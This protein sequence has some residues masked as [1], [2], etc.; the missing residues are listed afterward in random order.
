L[1]R[2][3]VAK[4]FLLQ[5]KGRNIFRHWMEEIDLIL[6][7]QRHC[8]RSVIINSTLKVFNGEKSKL[9]LF[10]QRMNFSSEIQ[11]ISDSCPKVCN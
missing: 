8:C 2:S 11:T 5:G 6:S 9:A 7:V 10:S 4:I 1:I 3:V